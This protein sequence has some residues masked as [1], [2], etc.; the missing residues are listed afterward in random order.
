MNS[1]RP[2]KKRQRVS[3]H[4]LYQTMSVLRDDGFEKDVFQRH[5]GNVDRDRMKR[6]RLAGQLFGSRARQQRD[7]PSLPPDSRDAWRPEGWLR[8]ITVEHELNPPVAF[9]QIVE[10]AGHHRTAA[11]DDRD[12]IGNL[13][14][15]GD[16]VR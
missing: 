3:S 7:H 13:L 16:L 4:D 5:W 10:R 12:V 15:L 8:R 11:I 2:M 6:A 14:N 1:P 9:A